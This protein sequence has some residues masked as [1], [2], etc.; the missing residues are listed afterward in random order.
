MTAK[1]V[2]KFRNSKG[3][4]KIKNWK[5]SDMISQ[6]NQTVRCDFSQHARLCRGRRGSDLDEVARAMTMAC[7][8]PRM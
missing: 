8:S 4:V 2:V 3:T 6:Q 5:D 1:F 7:S